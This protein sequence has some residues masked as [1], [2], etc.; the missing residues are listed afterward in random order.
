MPTSRPTPTSPSETAREALKELARRR[1]PPTPDNY[2]SVWN[3][4]SGSLTRPRERERE[5]A[6]D[7]A[8]REMLAGTLEFLSKP[9]AEGEGDPDAA[10][11]ARQCREARTDADA[12]SLV[13]PVKNLWLRWD[14]RGTDRAEI[15]RGLH[16]LLKLLADNVGELV[17]DDEWMAGQTHILRELLA[18]PVTKKTLREAERALRGVLYQQSARKFTLDQAK[19]SIKEMVAVFATGLEAH[20]R[21][22]GAFQERIAQH[23]ERM[24][25]ANDYAQVAKVVEALLADTR[26]MQV[27]TLRQH[28]ALESQR[29][30]AAIQEARVR[31]LEAEL[32]QLSQLV[33][34][35]PLTGLLNRR[36][37]EEAFA[38][39]ASR[40][41]RS[42]ARLSLALLDVDHFKKLNDR[43]GHAA[44]DRALEHLADVVRD[45]L[46]PTDVVARFGGEE[47]V[48]VLPGLE[49]G[50]AAE[51]LV[52]VQ[53]ALTRRCFL[54][55]EEKVFITFSAGVAA[56]RAGESREALLERADHALMQA[57]RSG[58][59][60]VEVA[61]PD[62]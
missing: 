15:S 11:L 22:T 4:L 43:L 16:G 31:E 54:D 57:K 46:R 2:A 21:A 37:F 58:R 44:G 49:A 30:R 29:N 53:R 62:A 12:R 19:A 7:S 26:L 9:D 35:D 52:R 61:G 18:R 20:C 42:G 50:P 3:E 5:P 14:L 24:E 59:N 47:F 25:A 17:A 32:T 51:V 28:E 55:N 39:E 56:Q 10:L 13:S 36:G 23:K 34:E 38:A 40:G 60:R 27:E 33:K 8:W 41:E 45:A 48:I 6:G 1:L